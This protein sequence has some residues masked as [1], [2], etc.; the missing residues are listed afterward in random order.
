MP[1]SWRILLMIFSEKLRELKA[2]AGI[3]EAKLAALSGLKP[4]TLHTYIL[5]SRDPSFAA[6]VKLAKAFGVSV[7]VFANCDDMTDEAPKKTATGKRP[8]DKARKR[9]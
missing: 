9:N 2:A 8:V 3:T 4:G 6:V 5:G 1:D 7:E